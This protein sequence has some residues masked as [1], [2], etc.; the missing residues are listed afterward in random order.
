MKMVKGKKRGRTNSKNKKN[1]IEGDEKSKIY[2]TERETFNE[3]YWQGFLKIRSLG[4][5]NDYYYLHY[6]SI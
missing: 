2:L 1:R 4:S 5:N 6:R 3:I